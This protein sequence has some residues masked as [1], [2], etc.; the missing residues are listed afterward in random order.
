MT[1]IADI[2]KG[3]M[4]EFAWEKMWITGVAGSEAT[5]FGSRTATATN[6]TYV[7][8]H[9]TGAQVELVGKGGRN[10]ALRFLRDTLYIFKADSIHSVK[11]NYLDSTTTLYVPQPYS[12]TGGAVNNR[13]TVVVENDIWFLTPDNEIRS[14]GSAASY[15]DPRTRDISAIIKK[16]KDTLAPDQTPYA[17]AHYSNG[18]YTLALAEKNSPCANI[19][20]TYNFINRGFGIDR[21]PSVKQWAN[22]GDK[23]FM[24]TK[25]SG[26]LYRDRTGYSFGG[27]FEIPFEVRLPFDDLGSP[28]LNWR[29]RRVYIRGSRSRGVALTVRLYRGNYDTYTDFILPEPTA[30]DMATVAVTGTFG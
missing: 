29:G 25:D 20:I 4:I 12:T 23:V 16:I 2:P 11:P 27:D 15:N 6:P 17:V 18:R 30:A 9:T 22:V 28:N 5:L 7:E 21:F 10:T 3:T 13:S 8:D 1:Q 14:L 24:V 19:V 26:Q